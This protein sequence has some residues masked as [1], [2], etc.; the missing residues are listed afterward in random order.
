MQQAAVVVHQAVPV[1]VLQRDAE[2][3]R[4]AA[5][6]AVT[7]GQLGQLQVAE[8]FGLELRALFEACLRDGEPH[9]AGGAGRAALQVEEGQ[10]VRLDL[11]TTVFIDVIPEVHV[12]AHGGMH[13]AD[14]QDL[15][16]V[17]EHPH[18]VIAEEAVVQRA[19]VVRLEVELQL[20][21]HAEIGV[22]VGRRIIDL[23]RSITGS[24]I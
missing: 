6:Q 23:G 8:P 1:L 14:V 15:L 21:A 7:L 9:P 5:V 4:L 2:R 17:Q 18:V 12:L 20:E 22:V 11:G 10:L 16:A 19:D 24:R 3:E 13:A